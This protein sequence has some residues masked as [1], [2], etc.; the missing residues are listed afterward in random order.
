MIKPMLETCDSP[1][2][3]PVQSA[4][5]TMLKQVT[6]ILESEQIELEDAL[7]RVLAEHVISTINVPPND[8]SAMDGYAMRCED[9]IDNNQLK[10]VG[11]A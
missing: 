2:L 4:I 7:G 3:L 1:G 11:T 10:L 9:F 8:N 6:A 5:S